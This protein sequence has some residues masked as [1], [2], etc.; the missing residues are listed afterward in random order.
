MKKALMLVLCVVMFALCACGKEPAQTEA[1]KAIQ[2]TSAAPTE[3]TDKVPE[4]TTTPETATVET[5]E[6][7]QDIV[8][9]IRGYID[10]PIEE[11]YDLIGE[12][13]SS[14]YASSCMGD[15]EDGLLVYDGF[16]V[17]TYREGDVETVYDVE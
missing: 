7:E 16:V 10:K 2:E 3:V 11:L 5:T 12:P 8:E 1:T 13:I 17:Y 14:D 9:V 15:G 6:S 4:E